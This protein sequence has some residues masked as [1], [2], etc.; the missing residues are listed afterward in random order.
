MVKLAAKDV[1]LALDT[2]GSMAGQ[3]IAQADEIVSL[4]L[5]YVIVT[6]YTSFLVDE[7]QNVLA[8]SG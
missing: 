5:R 1:I 2:S 8:P 6:P 4:S 3:K 7:R